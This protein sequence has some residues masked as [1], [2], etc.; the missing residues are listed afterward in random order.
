MTQAQDWT[1]FRG[2]NG[3]GA[4]EASTIPATWTDS[5]YNWSVEL[6]GKGHSSPVVWG[7]KIFLLSA[8]P[9]NATR[10]MLCLNAADGKTLWKREYPTQTHHL[11]VRSSY[12]SC[13]PAVDEKFV[14]VA[15]S[16]PE[17]TWFKAFDHTGIEVWSR[18]LGTWVSQHGFGTSPVIVGDIVALSCSQEQSDPK[19]PNSPKPKESFIVG[20]DRHTG[21]VRWRT[22]RVVDSAAYTVPCLR[23]NENG[24]DELVYCS[25]GEGIFA[26]DPATGK[27]N[28]AYP[29]AFN[30][31]TVSSPVLV[32]DLVLGSC[33]SGGG[34]S[35]VVAIKP[36]KAA[37]GVY[38]VKKEAPYVPTPVA[39]GDLVF[40]WSDK[41]IVNCIQGGDGKVLGTKRLSGVNSG[42]SGS[43]I[44]VK[45]K[46]YCMDEGGQVYVLSA[47]KE[48]KE[49]GRIPLG[50]ESRSTPAVAG[51][52][53][54]LRTIS[55]LYSIGG[56]S[57]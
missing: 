17:H 52:R 6:P 31:R 56:K 32:G 55:H 30:L 33:G 57:T 21:E 38:E 46:L 49:L 36:G 51:G 5:D 42:F 45:D 48:L 47:D 43:P 24:K 50:E 26:L 28:W 3:Q 39:Y 7:T 40:L 2:P 23:K 13:T 4:S 19:N 1:R 10:Y 29:K 11:H 27:E 22:E 35:R 12:A 14:Y 18:D 9:D 15:W 8:D 34:G 37:E 16:D 54:Y 44:R 41:G 20:V 53:M 25:Q